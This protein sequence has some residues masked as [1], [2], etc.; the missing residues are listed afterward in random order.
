MSDSLPIPITKYSDVVAWSDAIENEDFCG[1][2][3]FR[4]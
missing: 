4:L 3:N 1:I 2:N